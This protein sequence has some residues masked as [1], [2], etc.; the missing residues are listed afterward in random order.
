MKVL[1]VADRWDPLD[2]NQASG[3]DYEIYNAF[4]RAGAEVEIVGPFRYDFS[5]VERALMKVH[6]M[7]W[8][9]RL[10]KYPFQHFVKSAQH[11]NRAIERVD[12]D[13]VVAKYAAPLVFANLK[14]PLLYLSDG[15]ARWIGK[16]WD[17]FSKC[18]YFTMSMWEGR[19][20]RKC[21]RIVTYSEA[22][23]EVLRKYYGFPDEKLTVFG[24]PASIP[25]E[26]IP[27][28]IDRNKDLIPVKLLLVGRDYRRKGVDIALEIVDML[29]QQGVQA[30]LRI[31]GLDRPNTEHVKFMGFYNK[32]VPAEL[33]DYIANY[34][35]ANFLLHPA[36]FEAAGIVP[37][38]A[39]AFGVPT[40][41]NDT[42]GLATTVEDGVSGVVLPEGSPPGEYVSAVMGFVESPEEYWTLAESA[43]D[44]YERELNWQVMGKKVVEL[45]GDFIKE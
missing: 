29:N 8:E 31:V 39:A 38:E 37:S 12:H 6:G 17:T 36:R 4:L 16:H 3:V 13:L 19:V 1:H 34:R 14:K 44:R 25:M 35:W 40:L 26:E 45:A 41:T 5:L 15:T 23:A 28:R 11:V 22:N 30:E 7:F 27:R 42:G 24:I 33:T 2:H 10:L 32:T 20:I 21:D 9:R 18:T 43:R